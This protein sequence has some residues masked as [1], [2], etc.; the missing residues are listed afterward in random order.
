MR[1]KIESIFLENAQIMK[2]AIICMWKAN[3]LD[4]K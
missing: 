1:V 2:A 3:A 4:Y